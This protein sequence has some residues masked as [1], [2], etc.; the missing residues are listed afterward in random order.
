MS[1]PLHYATHAPSSDVSALFHQ[2]TVERTTAQHPD[3]RDP[4]LRGGPTSTPGP[5]LRRKPSTG[6]CVLGRDHEL[7]A[8][9]LS[10]SGMRGCGRAQ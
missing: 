6:E 7:G 3:H 4:C 8:S 2:L 1:A 10:R 9:V 5:T